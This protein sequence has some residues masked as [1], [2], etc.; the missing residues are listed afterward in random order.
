MR[1]SSF[2]SIVSDLTEIILVYLHNAPF[3]PLIKVAHQ[4]AQARGPG[5]RP[6]VGLGIALRR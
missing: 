3:T 6:V 5:F 4:R 1:T 2:N